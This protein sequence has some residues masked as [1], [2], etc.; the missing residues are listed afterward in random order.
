MKFPTWMVAEDVLTN[1]IS[2]GYAPWSKYESSPEN[3]TW[4][5]LAA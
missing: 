1:H 3:K 2:K 4:P 5:R